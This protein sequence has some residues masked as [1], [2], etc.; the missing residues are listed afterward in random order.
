MKKLRKIFCACMLALFTFLLISCTP[1]TV[2]EAKKKMQD[3]GYRVVVTKEKDEER[4][5][6]AKL[7]CYSE[8]SSDFDVLFAYYFDSIASAK[9]YFGNDKDLKDFSDDDSIWRRYD[10]WVLLG[11][12]EAIRDFRN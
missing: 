2:E 4:G 11:S 12:R 8:N 10:R 1:D 6:L 5:L 7:E 3:E 9:E